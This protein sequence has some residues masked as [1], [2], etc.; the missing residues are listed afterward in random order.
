MSRE[1]NATSFVLTPLT[2]GPAKRDSGTTSYCCVH[3]RSTVRDGQPVEIA[4]LLKTYQGRR[5]TLTLRLRIEWTDAGNGDTIGTGTWRI[6][7]GT[8]AY[9]DLAGNGRLSVV[10][11]TGSLND[12]TWRAVGYVSAP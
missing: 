7:S 1:D 3:S 4:N 11:E 9:A 8:A 10:A 12:I 5:G 2:A 6:A